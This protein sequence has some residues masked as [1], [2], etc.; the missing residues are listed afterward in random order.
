[1]ELRHSGRKN[2]LGKLRTD[3][4]LALLMEEGPAFIASH[5]HRFHGLLGDLAHNVAGGFW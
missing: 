4:D 2:L 1:M 3:G 5:H